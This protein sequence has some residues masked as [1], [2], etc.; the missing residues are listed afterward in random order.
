[1][2][3]LAWNCRGFGNPQKVLALKKEINSKG[4]KFVFLS[5]TRLLV[6]ELRCVAYKL[7]FN[8]C[9]GVDCVLSGRGRCGGLGLLWSVD[10]EV[11]LRSFS[12]NHIDVRVG[13]VDVW[14]LMGIYG[15]PEYNNKWCTWRLLEQLATGCSL[16]WL[17]VGD[18]NEILEDSE[19]IVEIYEMM[20]V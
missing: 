17:C 10:C 8:F 14:R 7:G 15:H 1:M 5:E 19:K 4:P 9:L 13:E 18:F 11:V 20:I 12:S 3:C 6:G 2:S 16:L